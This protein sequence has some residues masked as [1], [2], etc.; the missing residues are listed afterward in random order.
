MGRVS[1]FLINVFTL[2][3]TLFFLL[4]LRGAQVVIQE[5]IEGIFAFVDYTI[6][7]ITTWNRI[8][9]A[10]VSKWWM[11]P[12]ISPITIAALFIFLCFVSGMH[13]TV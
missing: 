6:F 8:E 7:L 3:G 1:Y 5:I 11:I 4:S 2:A 9:D 10:G 12:A 13:D